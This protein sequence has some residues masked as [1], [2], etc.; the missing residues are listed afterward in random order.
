MSISHSSEVL[1]DRSSASST[2]LYTSSLDSV[3]SGNCAR[4]A[5]SAPICSLWS[6]SI[7][8]KRASIWRERI[9]SITMSRTTRPQN[10]KMFMPLVSPRTR[11]LSRKEIPNWCPTQKT[12]PQIVSEYRVLGAVRVIDPTI[13]Q[14][15]RRTIRCNMVPK[16]RQRHPATWS[17]LPTASD[18]RVGRPNIWAERFPGRRPERNGLCDNTSPTDSHGWV[19]ASPSRLPRAWRRGRCVLHSE[20]LAA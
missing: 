1:A 5:A 8:T 3:F 18:S 4:R 16:S 10:K 9:S 20:R 19:I 14:T 17:M 11:V 7:D 2:I 6:C 13:D 15:Q 12:R